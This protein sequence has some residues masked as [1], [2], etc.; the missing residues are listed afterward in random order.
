MIACRTALLFISCSLVEGYEPPRAASFN[1]GCLFT[2]AK[3]AELHEDGGIFDH[4]AQGADQP[5]EI[6]EKVLLIQR[7]EED[8]PPLSA[9]TVPSVIDSHD[10][11]N[12]PRRHT[13]HSPADL[14]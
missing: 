11:V 8:L 10:V 12:V 2:A 14:G 5:W 1:C 6:G 4:G 7:V 13:L 9:I 3:H